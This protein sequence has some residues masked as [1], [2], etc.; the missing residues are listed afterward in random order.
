MESYK[1]TTEAQFI[2]D[3]LPNADLAVERMVHRLDAIQSILS[4]LDDPLTSAEKL[5][6]PTIS[7]KE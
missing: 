7:N 2:I 1:I 3:S 4:N 5:E 6:E